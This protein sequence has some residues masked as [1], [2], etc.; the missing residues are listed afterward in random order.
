MSVRRGF[1]LIE[2]LVVIAIFAILIGLLLPAIQKIRESAQ[3]AKSLNNLKQMALALHQSADT[4]NGYIGGVVKP[5]PK[6]WAEVNRLDRLYGSVMQETPHL[7]I[8]LAMGEPY[9]LINGIKPYFLS[10][11][12]PSIP[13]RYGY[14]IL[15]TFGSDGQLIPAG[16]MD[17]GPTSYA[18]NMTAFTGPPQFPASYSDGTSNTIAFAERYYESYA[19]HLMPLVTQD[20]INHG[21][22]PASW[23]L[24]GNI[25]PAVCDIIPGVLNNLNERRTSFADA[26]WGDVVPVTAGSPPTTRPSV[27]GKTFQ[28]RPKPLDADMAVPQTPFSAGLPVALFD[29]SV[30]TVRAGVRPEVFWALV[31]PAGGEVA[32]LD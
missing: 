24:Y 18:F 16:Y 13:P 9:S 8:A 17:G 23:L 11:A 30:R 29:G 28:T 5:D 26:G 22:Y 12:D 20:N 27:A 31:S 15:Q 3:R 14:R 25:N 4:R 10:P 1:S 21:I 6:S 7:V 2:L 32:S 19:Q